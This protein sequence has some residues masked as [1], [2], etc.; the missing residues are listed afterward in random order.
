MTSRTRSSVAVAAAVAL[1]FFGAAC[2][3]ADT[4][5]SASSNSNTVRAVVQ[6]RP[7]GPFEEVE[8]EVHEAPVDPLTVAADE[9]DLEEDELVIGVVVD[10][11]AVAYPVR[12]LAMSE[13]INDRIGDTPI[14]P[15]W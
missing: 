4:A 11:E 13:V 6:S 3:S 9:V 5:E 2:D 7:G 1:G 8:M 14:A 12:Y 10:G 15:S